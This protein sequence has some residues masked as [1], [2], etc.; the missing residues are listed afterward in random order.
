M[1]RRCIKQVSCVG[2]AA[3]EL[4]HVRIRQPDQTYQPLR[5]EEE[6]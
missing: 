3:S 6:N 2:L 5:I 1:A 4:C